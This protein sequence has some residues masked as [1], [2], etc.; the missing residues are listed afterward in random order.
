MANPFKIGDKVRLKQGKSEYSAESFIATGGYL[1]RKLTVQNVVGES[2]W[3][4]PQP[5][6][7]MVRCN[8]DDFELAD[9]EK[10]PVTA[11]KEPWPYYP[12]EHEMD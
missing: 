6:V 5:G 9:T 3:L 1:S 12:S 7:P 8:A 2:V 10:V 11:P 4:C